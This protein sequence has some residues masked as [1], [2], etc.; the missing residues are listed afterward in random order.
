MLR[1][2]DVNANG[3]LKIVAGGTLT[4]ADYEELLPQVEALLRERGTLRFYIEL[5]E[6]SGFELGA[7]WEDITFDRKHMDSFGKVAVVGDRRWEEWGTKFSSLFF[8]P[9]MKFFYHDKADEAWAWIN[10]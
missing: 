1:V 4:K 5:E 9:E 8:S 10:A 6:F 7:L 2:G 3:V